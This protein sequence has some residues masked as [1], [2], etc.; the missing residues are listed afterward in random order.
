MNFIAESY[1]ST[2][3]SSGLCGSDDETK[4][5]GTIWAT[6]SSNYTNNLTAGAKYVLSH[7]T[8][9]ANSAQVIEQCLA[10]YD[11]V[12]YLHYA[13]ES[14]TYNDFMNRVSNNFVTPLQ[15]PSVKLLANGLGENTNTIAIIVV[16]SMVSVTA[17]G[18][19]FFLKKR[20]EQN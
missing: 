18:G 15:A 12:I 2:F 6:L 8:A 3:N 19:Y 11:R 7:A 14:S 9:N 20:R 1:A 10:K 13:T 17:I 16:I 5:S 4:A